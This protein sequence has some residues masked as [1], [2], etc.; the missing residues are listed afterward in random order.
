M[1]KIVRDETMRDINDT[2]QEIKYILSKRSTLSADI[3][4]GFHIDGNESD[5]SARI[6]YLADAIG[7]TPAHMNYATD[8]FDYGSWED[9]FFMP[10]PCMLKYDGTVDYYLDPND[11]SKK[12]DGS[13]SD[14]ADTTYNGN[15]MM[16][17]GKGGRIIWYNII[18]EGNDSKSATV[19]ISN[20]QA[21]PDFKAY[22]FKDKND[23]YIEHFYTPCY[24]GSIV[25]DGTNDVLRSLSGRAGSTRC[26]SKTA[27]VERQMAQRNGTSWDIEFYC[28][29]ILI[30][31]LLML[32][33]K[34]TDTEKVFGEGLHTS[35]TDAI[36]DSFT[37]GQHDTKGLFYGTNSGAAATYANAVKVFGMENW[38]GF[39]WRRIN[40]LVAI[41]RV[42][43]YKLTYGTS[44]G[45]TA[46]DYQV[47]DSNVYSGYIT[48]NTMASASGTYID[49]MYFDTKQFSPSTASGTA[50]THY[51]D[52]LWN[53]TG[54]RFAYRGG[55]SGHAAL[56]GAFSLALYH[57]SSLAG[58]DV[59]AAPAAKPI[60]NNT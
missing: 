17:W 5:P 56:V 35:G 4:Y 22:S 2:L 33:G 51:C 49:A 32:I 11:Y 8:K 44:D 20:Y 41:D 57:A 48:A 12:R 14:V 58:W 16:E 28:D 19:Y 52:G 59:G 38:W 53:N 23:D 26:K 39:M 27:S 1:G 37:S 43:K 34:S 18:P 55:S 60:K 7:M 54:T 46:T 25:N 45:S 50:S 6:T 15:A 31:L 24:F 10:R 29:T 9:A 47:S 40:G 21:T 36:N 13:T 3:M 42:V 30:Q